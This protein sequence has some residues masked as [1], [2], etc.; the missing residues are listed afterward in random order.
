MA[1]ASAENNV[2]CVKSVQI[3]IFFWSVFSCN[4]AE[5]GDLLHKLLYSANKDQNVFGYFSRSGEFM[6]T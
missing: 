6:L 3:R 1:T 4:Q 5:Y 2:N